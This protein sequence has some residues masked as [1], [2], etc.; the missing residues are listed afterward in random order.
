MQH[1]KY[2]DLY[3]NGIIQRR[4]RCD[5][6]GRKYLTKM[7]QTKMRRDMY[8]ELENAAQRNPEKIY[9]LE[10]KTEDI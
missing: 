3:E 6:I 1:L 9:Y 10:L 2:I 5:K 8:K 4:V 7:D